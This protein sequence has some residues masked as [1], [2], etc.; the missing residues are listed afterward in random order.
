MDAHIHV[1]SYTQADPK[2]TTQ[3]ASQTYKHIYTHSDTHTLPLKLFGWKLGLTLA[4]GWVFSS[5]NNGA[6]SRAGGQQELLTVRD[7]IIHGG[8][9]HGLKTSNLSSSVWD[10]RQMLLIFTNGGKFASL[11]VPE[12]NA[13]RADQRGEARGGWA[14]LC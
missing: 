11:G 12:K 10:P 13:A 6:G 5:M 7:I 3:S 1:D 2:T 14:A 4:S 9:T 8:D